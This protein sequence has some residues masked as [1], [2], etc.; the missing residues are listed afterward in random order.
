MDEKIKVINNLPAYGS[1]IIE[2]DSGGIGGE[3]FLREDEREFFNTTGK[4]VYQK[5]KN[6]STK[7]LYELNQENEYT[8]DF[9]NL[10]AYLLDIKKEFQNH[11][12]NSYKEF[13]RKTDE[14]KR[15][16]EYG[17]NARK[18]YIIDLKDNLS[19]Q[20]YLKK[21]TNNRCFFGSA[22]SADIYTKIIAYTVVP[23]YTTMTIERIDNA[24]GGAKYIFRLF[25]SKDVEEVEETKQKNKAIAKLRKE[26]T[27]EELIAEA[28]KRQSSKT[29]ENGNLAKNPYGYANRKKIVSNAYERDD[30]VAAAVKKRALGKCDLCEEN[31]PFLDEHG[32]P[33]LEEHHVEWLVN[34]GA[35]TI[36]NAVALCPNCHRK[37]HICNDYI[38]VEKLFAKIEMYK[39]KYADIVNRII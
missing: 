24:T 7:Q 16:D 22:D 14:N 9:E 2:K 10:F 19:F 21:S 36:D 6:S 11:T 18:N 13:S 1:L 26:K 29:K 39:E 34:G 30:I 12:L 32:Q 25:L 33:F 23:N 38:D 5:G 3:V 17:W 28:I 27:V 35:D 31:A 8:F 37:M 4:I 15:V 20:L